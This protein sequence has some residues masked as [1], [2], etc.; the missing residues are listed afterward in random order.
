MKRISEKCDILIAGAGP[1]GCSAAMNLPDDFRVL[2]ADGSAFP[3]NKTC[4]G[5]LL[6]KS[7]EFLE[8]T[9]VVPPDRVF[10]EPRRL[11]MRIIDADNDFEAEVKRNFS[12]VR[13]SAFDEW[14]LGRCA[15]KAELRQLSRLEDVRK[16]LDGFVAVINTPSGR[17]KILSKCVIDATGA[18][19]FSKASARIKRPVY[20][21]YQ[22]K[23]KEEHD[24]FF[25]FI[26]CNR[27]TDYYIWSIPKDGFTLVGTAF[28]PGNI[29]EKIPLFRK[30]VRQEMGIKKRPEKTEA[31]V[32][33]RPKKEDIM[34]CEGGKLLAG[35]A[36]GLVSPNTGEGISFALRSGRFCA[37]AIKKNFDDP[38]GAYAGYCSGLVE[39][40]CEKTEASL[41]CGDTG[42]RIRY[43]KKMFRRR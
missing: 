4:G 34:F 3:R 16:T 13:R 10:A 28:R 23:I 8:K 38:T 35:E 24:S 26:L 14:L 11:S 15:R 18:H 36:A 39:E 1:A 2:L 19:A 42:K 9:G 31:G 37:E 43:L 29:S 21:A 20:V 41:V 30:F 5:V 22:E 17:E 40:I 25:D 27:I 33:L 6:E 32:L 12:N 7:L